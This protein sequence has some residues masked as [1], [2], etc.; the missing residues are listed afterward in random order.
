MNEN[1]NHNPT[2]P[3]T[4]PQ[5]EAMWPPKAI[6]DAIWLLGN[7]ALL[8]AIVA[9]GVLVLRLLIQLVVAVLAQIFGP[10]LL[11]LLCGLVLIPFCL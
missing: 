11:L 3:D 6:M 1:D 9:V 4:Q 2:T 10:F 5:D 8:A 7:L